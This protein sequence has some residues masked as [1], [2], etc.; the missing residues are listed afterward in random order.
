MHQGCCA[1]RAA[2]V[3][4]TGQHGQNALICIGTIIKARHEADLQGAAAG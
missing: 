1:W 2:Q 4:P 3:V